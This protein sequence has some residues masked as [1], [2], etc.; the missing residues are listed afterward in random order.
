MIATLER[1][2]LGQLLLDKGLVKPE[3][4]APAPD[5]QRRPTHQRRRGEALVDLRLCTEDQITEALAQ[6]YGVPYA[7][8]SP[9]I[10][11]PKVI[12]SLP[13]DFLEKHSVLPLFL[14]DGMLTV[15]VP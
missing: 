7:R 5:R 8:V 13:K 10:A 6:A 3:Q 11:D 2:P 14:V 4:L 9:R 1:K 15:A 12:A